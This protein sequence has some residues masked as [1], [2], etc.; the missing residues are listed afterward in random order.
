M[1]LSYS[2]LLV[3]MMMMMM[4]ISFTVVISTHNTAY[5][6]MVITIRINI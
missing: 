4:N 5:N 6:K 2:P 3:L 1:F